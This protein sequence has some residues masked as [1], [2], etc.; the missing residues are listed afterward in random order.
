[1]EYA[2]LKVDFDTYINRRSYLIKVLK[3]KLGCSSR[4]AKEM[5]DNAKIV[6][7][8]PIKEEYLNKAAEKANRFESSL[9]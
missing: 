3:E 1:M 4:E 7:N 2:Y 5:V 8:I 9:E 6:V